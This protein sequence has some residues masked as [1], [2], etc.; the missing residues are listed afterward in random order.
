MSLYDNMVKISTVRYMLKVFT[1]LKYICNFIPSRYSSTGIGT[2]NNNF[3]SRWYASFVMFNLV[4]D[5]LSTS[6]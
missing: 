2:C 1:G 4:S 6:N 5:Q 3:L